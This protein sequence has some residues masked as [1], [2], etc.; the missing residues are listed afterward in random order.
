M[1]DQKGNVGNRISPQK[2]K[3]RGGRNYVKRGLRAPKKSGIKSVE[4]HAIAIQDV[5][6]RA[7]KTMAQIGMA[8]PAIAARLGK[9]PDALRREYA[10]AFD[11][12]DSEGEAALK[13]TAMQMAI[14]SPAQYD[15]KGRKIRDEIKPSQSM[16]QFVLSTRYGMSL[17]TKHRVTGPGEGPVQVRHVISEDELRKLP[18]DVLYGL[19]V[20]AKRADDLLAATVLDAGRSGDV[21]PGMD[22]T[23][24]GEG[25]GRGSETGNALVPV[26]R[27]NGMAD[28]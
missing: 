5:T 4:A 10:K 14:G 8:W 3:S 25:P 20:A 17:V 24:G 13:Q 27:G 11:E 21:S 7:V 9:Q 12:G 1:D 23:A 19:M 6:Y 15:E 26:I 16:V 18:E 22:G 2:P 28:P